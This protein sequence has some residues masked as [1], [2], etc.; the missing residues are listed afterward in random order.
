M[1]GKLLARLA[2]FCL[3]LPRLMDVW[4]E[5]VCV[6]INTEVAAISTVTCQGLFKMLY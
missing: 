6:I 2:V 4:H 5:A 3:S 1:S